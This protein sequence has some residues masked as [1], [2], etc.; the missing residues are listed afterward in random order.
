MV[1]ER[2][3]LNLEVTTR[4]DEQH[5]ERAATACVIVVQAA[6]VRAR[7]DLDRVM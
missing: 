6:A 2:E 1:R 7:P 4:L 5:H 3:R